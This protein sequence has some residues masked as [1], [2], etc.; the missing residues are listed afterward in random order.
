MNIEQAKAIPISKILEKLDKRPVRQNGHQSWFYAPWRDEKTA[1]LHVHEKNNWWYDFGIGYGGNAL[2]LVQYHLNC[3]GE[4]STVSDAL[5]WLT[6]MLG[7]PVVI[8]AI[9]EKKRSK[10]EAALI[11]KSVKPI[12]HAAL[13]NYLDRRGIAL[14]VAKTALKEVRVQH[15]DTKKNLFALGIMN[16]DDG[17]EIRNP[18]IKSCIGPKAITFVRG[19]ETKPTGIHIFEGFMDYLSVITQNEGKQ[20]KDDVIILNSVSCLKQATAY[21]K[22]YGYSVMRT[23]LDNDLAGK[24]ATQ[25]LKEFAATE[26]NLTHKPMNA[27]YTPYKDVNAWHMVKLGL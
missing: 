4:A 8:K 24:K 10:T 2:S 1:S 13:V 26:I 21:I 27:T 19:K 5:R 14:S 6:N 18:L 17:W 9:P 15:K 12:H 11:L 16:E 25:A 22:G 3:S 23:W 7:D 20:F